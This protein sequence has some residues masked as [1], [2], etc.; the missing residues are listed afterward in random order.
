V[1]KALAAGETDAAVS[2]AKSD[3]TKGSKTDVEKDSYLK[4]K[5]L[6]RRLQFLEIQEEY[7]KDEV[8]NLKR[9]LLRAQEE[10]RCPFYYHFHHRIF[11]ATVRSRAQARHALFALLATQK[12][13]LTRLR[14]LCR[15]SVSSLFLSLLVNFWK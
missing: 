11:L 12:F 10:V 3:G 4:L 2:G 13:L 7:I 14:L 9:E 15:S 8:K 5:N 1:Q 6:E